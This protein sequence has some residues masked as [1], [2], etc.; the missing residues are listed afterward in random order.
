MDFGNLL[1]ILKTSSRRIV[2]GSIAVLGLLGYLSGVQAASQ[3]ED[4]GPYVVLLGAP[5]SGKTTH[6][7]ALGEKYD[8][9][10]LHA[11]ELLEKEIRRALNYSGSPARKGAATRRAQR[12]QRTLD[13]LEDGELVDDETLN[14]FIASRISQP[15]CQNGF[16]IDGYPNSVAQADFLDLY[17]QD[18]GIDSLAVVYLDISDEVARARMQQRA[19]TDDRQGFGEERLQQFRSNIEPILE[20]YD[21]EQLLR[22]DTTK[23]ISAVDSEIVDFL[24]TP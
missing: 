6:G 1:S 11:A 23:E 21:G 4:A 5:G 9:P 14:A 8:V 24:G 3:S 22:V 17:L 19:R 12:A 13:Q 2:A 15:D 10:V 18:R 20:F 7:D 16:V